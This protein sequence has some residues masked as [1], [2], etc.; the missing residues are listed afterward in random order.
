MYHHIQIFNVCTTG[1]G[2]HLLHPPIPKVFHSKRSLGNTTLWMHSVQVNNKSD[3]SSLH[4]WLLRLWSFGMWH[5]GREVCM[6]GCLDV[7]KET[8]ASD[9][10]LVDEAVLAPLHHN[11]HHTPR[12]P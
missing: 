3:P 9:F 8:A 6:F 11:T 5:T 7:W 1:A 12:R 2:I 10:M 4:H